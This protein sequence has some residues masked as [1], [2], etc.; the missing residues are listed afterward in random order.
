MNQNTDMKIISVIL[1]TALSAVQAQ[2]GDHQQVQ[3]PYLDSITVQ[4]SCQFSLCGPQYT[5]EF[6]EGKQEES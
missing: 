3:A 5:Q 6:L 4:D 2:L 1:V